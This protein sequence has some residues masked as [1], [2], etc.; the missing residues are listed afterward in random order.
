LEDLV[1]RKEVRGTASAKSL[2]VKT[3]TFAKNIS[4]HVLAKRN[5]T[6]M[7][8]RGAGEGRNATAGQSLNFFHT[9]QNAKSR[10]SVIAKSRSSIVAK[11]RSSIIASSDTSGGASLSLFMEKQALI[12]VEDEIEVFVKPN[13]PRGKNAFQRVRPKLLAVTGSMKLSRLPDK[14]I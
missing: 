8:V 2:L 6:V 13:G 9:V 11:S 10:P 5:S 4:M 1:G 7:H 14:Y 12:P 3:Q